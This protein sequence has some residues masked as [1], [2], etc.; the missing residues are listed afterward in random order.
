G[1]LAIAG[2]GFARL[3]VL[4]APVPT[5]PSGGLQMIDLGE[6]A[7]LFLTAINS[8]VPLPFPEHACDPLPDRPYRHLQFVRDRR[9]VLPPQHQ[10]PHHQPR[11]PPPAFPRG[12][13][14]WRTAGIVGV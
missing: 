12:F 7:R 6:L 1:L 13:G 8:S 3:A 5:V 10:F 14:S 4:Q 11:P 2:G 9:R